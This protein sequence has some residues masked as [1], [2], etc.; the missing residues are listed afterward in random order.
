[1]RQFSEVFDVRW[2]C[3]RP[4]ELKTGTALA[5]VLGNVYQFSTLFCFRVTSPYGTE[6]QTERRT[7]DVQ[8]TRNAVYCTERPH[9]DKLEYVCTA[10]LWR[11]TKN[12]EDELSCSA[13][14]AAKRFYAI[15]KWRMASNVL[16]KT[17]RNNNN[18]NCDRIFRAKRQLSSIPLN[19]TAALPAAPSNLTR[20][21]IN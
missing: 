4:S 17:F 13:L 10:L 20:P 7:D 9:K 12:T 15:S 19:R 6:G 1:M 3:L 11:G 14:P 18:L 16:P 8:D 21:E 5:R 2:L